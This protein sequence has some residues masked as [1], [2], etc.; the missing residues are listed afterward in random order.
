M[1]Y[2]WSFDDLTVKV[3][4]AASAS[5][6]IVE[7]VVVVGDEVVLSDCKFEDVVFVMS[8]EIRS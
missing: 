8:S 2:F 3:M 1:T 5:S 7:Y 6:D 4:W